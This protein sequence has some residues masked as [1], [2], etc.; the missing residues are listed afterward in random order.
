MKIA[1]GKLKPVEQ[2][3]DGFICCELMLNTVLARKDSI[4][5]VKLGQ[6]STRETGD[7]ICRFCS[8][9]IPGGI[10]IAIEPIGLSDFAFL[11]TIDIDEGSYDATTR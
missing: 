6:I 5:K 3:P 8:N 11:E 10:N 2:F 4:F 7:W 1:N 9:E